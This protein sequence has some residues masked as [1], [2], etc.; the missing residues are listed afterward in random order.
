MSPFDEKL[1][2]TNCVCIICGP[3]RATTGCC[4]SASI[5]NAQLAPC[6]CVC[7][8]FSN[9]ARLFVCSTS[10]WSVGRLSIQPT[11][12]PGLW[13]SPLPTYN[14]ELAEIPYHQRPP[15][16]NGGIRLAAYWRPRI[17]QTN[18]MHPI[19]LKLRAPQTIGHQRVAIDNAKQRKSDQPSDSLAHYCLA[20][21]KENT[22]L[23]LSRV[24]VSSQWSPLARQ[25]GNSFLLFP[26]A[27][28]HRKSLFSSAP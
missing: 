6:V 5:T 18:I 12:G 1:T 7:H 10:T 25:P 22:A 8:P 2:T 14:D 16:T 9:V 27:K 23:H 4:F 13:W 24:Q 11:S 17:A 20:D 3:L 21:C 28:S 26:S 15:P 19:D